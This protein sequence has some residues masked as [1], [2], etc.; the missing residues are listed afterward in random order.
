MAMKRIN[1]ELFCDLCG[2]QFQYQ[3]K[4]DRHLVALNHRRFSESLEIPIPAAVAD[5]PDPDLPGE[6][7]EQVCSVSFQ[8][9][10]D[11]SHDPFSILNDQSCQVFTGELW[12]C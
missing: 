1:A 8:P 9:D 11:G 10:L 6:G 2:K 4:Y 12:A 7:Q 3:S 5:E